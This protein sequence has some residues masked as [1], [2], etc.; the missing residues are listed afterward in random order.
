MTNILVRKS[1]NKNVA[2][3]P[4]AAPDMTRLMRRFFDW[5]PF[6]E[7]TVLPQEYALEFAPAFEVKET[8]DGYLFRADVPGVKEADID[9]TLTGSRLNI[10]GKREA[11]VEEKTD[12]HYMRERSYGSF[13]RLFTLPEG[14]D[15]N[16]V[17]ADLKDGVL[18][19]SLKKTPEVQP[20]KVTIQT[21]S[22]KS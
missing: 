14:I 13:Q 7:M 2:R 1:D 18:T 10:S 16:S 21:Q 15:S 20:R 5:D 12:M 17:R 3:S 9:V 8:K 19:V 22:T 4:L 6:S 11:D